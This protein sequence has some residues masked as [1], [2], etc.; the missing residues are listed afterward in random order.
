MCDMLLAGG[1]LAVVHFYA[2][3]AEKITYNLLLL[4]VSYNITTSSSL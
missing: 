4:F 3:I 1:A 2:D